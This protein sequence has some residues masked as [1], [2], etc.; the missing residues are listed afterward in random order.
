MRTLHT[1]MITLGILLISVAAIAGNTQSNARCMGGPEGARCVTDLPQHLPE[2]GEFQIVQLPDGRLVVYRAQ[3]G[4]EL[5]DEDVFVVDPF[6]GTVTYAGLFLDELENI[7]H[8]GGGMFLITGLV[9]GVDYDYLL[10]YDHIYGLEACP[11]GEC[12]DHVQYEPYFGGRI[13]RTIIL[14][15][16]ND[17]TSDVLG[18]QIIDE[19][20]DPPHDYWMPPYDP[21]E[22]IDVF[23]VEPV[24]PIEL[25]PLDPIDWMY[26]VEPVGF[27]NDL[28]PYIEDIEYDDFGQLPAER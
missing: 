25:P 12:L 11:N 13:E 23:P 22:P 9:Y 8:M 27:P 16:A 1:V 10:D 21:T 15:N 2:A 18:T 28:R 20:V 24:H 26:P 7:V 14:W 5:L 17:G 4:G 3:V 6:T 19:W